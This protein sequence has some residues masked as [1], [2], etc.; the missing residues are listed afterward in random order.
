MSRGKLVFCSGWS[1]RLIETGE[2]RADDPAVQT[3]DAL[4]KVKRCLEEAGT[5]LDNI[6]KLMIYVK[7]TPKNQ[8]IV[9][10]TYMDNLRKHAPSLA[11]DMPACTWIGVDCLAFPSMLVELDVTAIVPR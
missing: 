4:D 10:D 2:V 7:D 9:Q 6:V 5:S 11:E 8:K 1:G 3:V